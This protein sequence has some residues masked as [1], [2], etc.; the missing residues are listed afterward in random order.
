MSVSLTTTNRTIVLV[1]VASFTDPSRRMPH[2]TAVRNGVYEALKG[3]FTDVGVDWDSVHHEDRGDGVMILVPA[4]VPAISLA[5]PLL[6]R[7]LAALREH[8]AIHV[9]EASIRLR[10]VLHSGQVRLDEVGASGLALNFAFRLLDAPVVKRQLQE[11]RGI[12]AVV[13][14]E[15]F[16]RDVITQYPAA[17]ESDYQRIHAEREGFSS[18]AWLRVLGRPLESATPPEVLGQF[19]DEEM[20][21]VRGWLADLEVPDFDALAHR[22]AGASLPLPRFEDSWHA[23]AYLAD[24]NAGPDAVP[25]ALVF[26]DALAVEGS[27]VRAW[28]DEQIRRLNI[29][30]HFQERRRAMAH[31][32]DEPQLHLVIALERDGINPRLFVLSAW[33]QDDPEAWPPARADVRYVALDV[34]EDAFDKVVVAAEQAWAEQMTTVTLDVLLPR[35]LLQLPVHSWCRERDS[36]D[37][38]PLCLDYTIRLRSLDRLKATYWHRA[39]RE[40]WLSMRMDPSPVRILFTGAN[41]DRRRVDVALRE[42]NSVAIVLTEPPPPEPEA[43]GDEFIAAMRSGLPVVIWHPHAKP[44]ELATYLKELIS[45]GTLIDLLERLRQARIAALEPDPGNNI[46][47]A[48]DVVVLWDDPERQV[49]LG[50]ALPN[51]SS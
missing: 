45:L 6:D 16:Y 12:L 38:R 41:H 15:D 11:S 22:A 19:A 24:L 46:N 3:A 25:P 29:G 50:G 20:D 9:P 17:A 10:L 2:Q 47:L 31:V 48:S 32:V 14:S 35:E 26:L 5:D 18:G 36:V 42:H 8:N 49:V 7:V 44:E 1:D 13:A 39:W 28:V 51:T 27:A 40:R 21:L 34:I 23:F 4:T 37:P 30:A 43:K 33:R